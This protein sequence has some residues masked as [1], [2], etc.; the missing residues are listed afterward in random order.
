MVSIN[1]I[2]NTFDSNT[3]TIYVDNLK[4]SILPELG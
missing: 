4:I 3:E 2:L 1:D